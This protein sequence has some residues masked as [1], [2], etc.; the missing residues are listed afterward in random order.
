MNS[1]IVRVVKLFTLFC[2]KSYIYDIIS[3]CLFPQ[4][5]FAPSDG[6]SRNV[7]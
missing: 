6:F 2:E 3:V 4:I 5:T 1:N 7:V